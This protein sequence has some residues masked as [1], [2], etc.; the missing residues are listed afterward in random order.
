MCY[1][2]HQTDDIFAARKRIITGLSNG[3]FTILIT[4]VLIVKR[5]KK[6]SELFGGNG[7]VK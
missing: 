3:K 1:V 5:K 7:N 4:R 6:K 2:R